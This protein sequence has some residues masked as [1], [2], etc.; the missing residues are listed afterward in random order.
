MVPVVLITIRPLFALAM[1]R[2]YFSTIARV[3]DAMGLKQHT[4]QAAEED[5]DRKIRRKYVRG[6]WRNVTSLVLL[7]PV[8]AF[9]IVATIR[10]AIDSLPQPAPKPSPYQVMPI[11]GLRDYPPTK[12]IRE[13]KD[14]GV[15]RN[16]D[17]RTTRR[18]SDNPAP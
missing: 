5:G 14:M 17:R 2:S 13:E 4:R 8:A 10:L 3:S 6:I 18:T 15:P 9:G 1:Q 16:S 11:E 7:T 12:E